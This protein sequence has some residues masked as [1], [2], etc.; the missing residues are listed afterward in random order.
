M[1]PMPAARFAE[2]WIDA[3]NHRDVARVLA[4]YADD[5]EMASPYIVTI[6]REPSGRLRGKPAVERYWR[7][8]LEGVPHLRFELRSVLEGVGSFTLLYVGHDG[9]LVA[10]VM[11]PG[12]DGR[13]VRAHA[14]YAA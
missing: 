8:A 10:E 12:A 11:Q 14:H 2:E 1:H 3:W 4:L 13:V 6:A 9:R 7:R 5:F